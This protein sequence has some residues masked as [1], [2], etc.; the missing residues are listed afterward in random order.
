M[1]GTPASIKERLDAQTDAIE[2]LPLDDNTS[3][4]SRNV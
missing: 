1:I 4:T 3:D 2:V